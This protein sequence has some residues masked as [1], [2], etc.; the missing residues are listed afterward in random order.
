MAK[1]ALAQPADMPI[2][3]S[4]VQREGAVKSPLPASPLVLPVFIDPERRIDYREASRPAQIRFLTEDD[5]PP[6]HYLGRDNVLAGFNVDLARMICAELGVPC[7][8]QV[9]RWDLLLPALDTNGGDAVIASHRIDAALRR[10]F[11]VSSVVYRVPARFVARK[12]SDLTGV[13]VD[14]LAGR[15]VAVVG[16]S[17]HEAYL[18]ALFPT[19]KL[20]RFPTM[21][22]ALEAMRRGDADLAFGDG[23]SA[24]FWMNG[25]ESLACCVFLGGAFTESRFFG[26]GAGIVMR[27]GNTNLRQNVD[28][29]LWRISRDGRFAKLYLKHFPISFY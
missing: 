29:A 27:R 1:S 28:Y 26:E 18:N 23:V 14:S 20:S 22:R 16:G 15:I 17:A 13:G 3:S 12:T 10:D 21:E 2:S 7:T 5:Y 11:E 8:V 4:G 19:V 9:R 24:A 6:F 25:S